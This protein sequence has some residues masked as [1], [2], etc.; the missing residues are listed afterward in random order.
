M[1]DE[2]EKCM[3]YD[4]LEVKE[5]KEFIKIG[6]TIYD[7]E[8]KKI[9]EAKFVEIYEYVSQNDVGFEL[10]TLIDMVCTYVPSGVYYGYDEEREK[11]RSN[12]LEERWCQIK[13]LLKEEILEKEIYVLKNMRVE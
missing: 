12:K 3:P 9:K 1:N 10:D 5:F 8:N 4:C 11:Y 13:T 6:E 2:F 7:K